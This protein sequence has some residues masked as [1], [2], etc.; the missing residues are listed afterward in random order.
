[1]KPNDQSVTQYEEFAHGIGTPRT[2]TGARAIATQDHEVIRRW[3]ARRSAE[4]AT[5]GATA[6]GPATIDVNDGGAGIRFN[7]PGV[8]RFRPIT[9]DEWFENFD[10]HD[11]CF[12]YEEEVADRAYELWEARDR[13]PGRDREDWFEAEAQLRGPSSRALRRYRIVK[14]TRQA[15]STG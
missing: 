13:A 15:P 10:G 2:A 6:S 14:R 4:P 12:V 8:Q 7:F 9:W 3:A 1:M 5:G 11:L